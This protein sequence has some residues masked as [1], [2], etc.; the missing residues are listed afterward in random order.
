MP[1]KASET[2]KT[3]QRI[4][5]LKKKSGM[6]FRRISRQLKEDKLASISKSTVA[7]L[8]KKHVAEMNKQVER[9]LDGNEQYRLLKKE[10]EQLEIDEEKQRRVKELLIRKAESKQGLQDFFAHPKKLMEFAEATIADYQSAWLNN[11]LVWDS[12]KSHL[13]NP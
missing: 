5:E 13:S 12:F 9:E 11:P 3:V 1:S 7:N 4:I 6:G 2:S 10:V 8:Y